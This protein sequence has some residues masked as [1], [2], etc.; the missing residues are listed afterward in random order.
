VAAKSGAVSLIDQSAPPVVIA[1]ALETVPKWCL[2]D[3]IAG[4]AGM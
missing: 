2:A 1:M 4:A 3:G